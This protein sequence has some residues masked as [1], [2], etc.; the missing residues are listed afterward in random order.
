MM[1]ESLRDRYTENDSISFPPIQVE[2]Y[3]YHICP[4]LL[5][6]NRPVVGEAT[7]AVKLC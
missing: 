7:R 6:I 3:I 1:L 4:S 5:E 2:W